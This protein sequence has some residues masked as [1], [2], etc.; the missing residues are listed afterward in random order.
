M[1]DLET[2]DDPIEE[3]DNFLLRKLESGPW[4]ATYD[5]MD[6]LVGI[7][8]YFLER[9]PRK[10][11][12]RGLQSVL[13]H[14]E[15]MAEIS[16]GGITWFTAPHQVPPS[17]RKRAPDGY[18]NLGIANG[19]PGVIRFL[20]ELVL[21]RVAE[22]RAYPLLGGAVQWLLNRERPPRSSSRYSPWFI[23]GQE[24]RDSVVSWNYGDAAIGLVL[25]QVGSSVGREDWQVYGKSLLHQRCLSDFGSTDAG[26]SLPTGT[27][28]VAHILNRL[29][30]ATNDCRYKDVA[31]LWYRRSFFLSD[32]PSG[33]GSIP[34]V[35]RFAAQVRDSDVCLLSESVGMALSFISAVYSIEPKWDRML[36]LSGWERSWW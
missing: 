18:Y 33:T 19:I 30:Q 21:T 1:H 20:G 7:G 25:Q 12:Y 8:V 32:K 24:P 23:P 14:L 2:G 17:H 26:V 6:G 5:L 16:W 35:A 11:A 4:S 29:Y 31:I 15:R 28:G 22:E 3:I 34:G 9:L 36:L 27:L 10:S 13:G